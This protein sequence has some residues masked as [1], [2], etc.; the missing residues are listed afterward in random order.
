MA[1]LLDNAVIEI[2]EELS[3]VM[4]LT[5]PAPEMVKVAGAM[6]ATETVKSALDLLIPSASSAMSFS[7]TG[8][9]TLISLKVKLQ[10]LPF[11]N[12]QIPFQFA[13][14]KLPYS[15]CRA[16]WAMLLRGLYKLQV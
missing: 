5:I 10:W 4:G 1:D 15:R 3:Q 11:E 16:F 12:R 6:V 9:K 14:G 2:A 8:W 13:N 7:T